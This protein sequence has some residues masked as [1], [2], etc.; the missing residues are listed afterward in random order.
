[1]YLAIAT[2]ANSIVSAIN[3]EGYKAYRNDSIRHYC[4]FTGFLE[5]VSSWWVLLAVTGIMM[6]LFVKVIFQKATERFEVIYISVIFGVPVAIAL[7]PFA[8]L[9][10]G[11]SGAWCWIRGNEYTDCSTFLLGALLR[12]FL[13]YAPLYIL[14]F[15][16]LILLIIIFIKLR[17][18][19]RSWTGNFD[20]IALEMKRKMSKEVFPLISYPV[21]FLLLN[22]PPLAL[23][24]TNAVRPNEP[25]LALWFLSSIVFSLQGVVITIAFTLDPETR[26]DLTVMQLMGAFKRLVRKEEIEEYINE[27]PTE[28]PEVDSVDQFTD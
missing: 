4:V 10:Y 19:R 17:K 23:R 6:D 2:I 9:A 18:Q 8:E 3:V 14:M 5:Q 26:R 25:V 27:G 21:I 11:P 13:Y 28:E 20:P 12:F 1:M 24:I 16:L 7:I 22:I 15:I